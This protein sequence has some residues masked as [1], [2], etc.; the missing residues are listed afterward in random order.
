V[1]LLS[2]ALAVGAAPSLAAQV[3]ASVDVGAARV[4]YDAFLPAFAT[5]LG[6]GVQLVT[7]TTTLTARASLLHFE[8]GR[9]SL[10]GTA[11]ISRFLP[12]QGRWRAE[13][14]GAV[15]GSR[16]ADYAGFAHAQ[17]RVRLHRVGEESGQWLAL[18]GG[19][20]AYASR[21]R[22][23]SSYGAGAWA[24]RGG[25]SVE[26]SGTRFHVGDTSYTDFL[27]YTR[28]VRGRLTLDGALG[29]RVWSRGA[30]RGVWGE[31][32]AALRITERLAMVLAGGRY[33]DDPA[34]GS[35]SGRYATLGLRFAAT[36]EPRPLPVWRPRPSN[37]R[38]TSLTLSIGPAQSEHRLVRT[39]ANDAT[40]VEVRG[41]FTDWESVALSRQRDGAWETMLSVLP[42]LRRVQVR[43]NGG[44]WL[45]PAGMIVVADEFGG[46]VGLVMVQ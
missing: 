7:S 15:G 20:V 23:L 14:T 4:H 37:G 19:S 44:E 39:R 27:A 30:G 12:A 36:R 34:R 2:T 9:T 33:P 35:I 28:L 24:T 25:L 21:T 16:Y 32:N 38:E 31:G 45:P 3:T 17:G 41:D 22:P 1:R 8:T 5:S 10:Q 13:L 29:A 42:G 26:L 6:A 11:V 40:T 43:V 18:S 46:R